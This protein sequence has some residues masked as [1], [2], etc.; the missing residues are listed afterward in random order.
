VV[1]GSLLVGLASDWFGWLV[2]GLLGAAGPDANLL[3]L[4]LVSWF[5]PDW[6]FPGGGGELQRAIFL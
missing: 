4:H 5:I 1:R 6:S 2:C 3:D